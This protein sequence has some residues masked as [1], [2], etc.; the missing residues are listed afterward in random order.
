MLS[1]GAT[2]NTSRRIGRTASLPYLQF[3]SDDPYDLASGFS[4][5]P[6]ADGYV[7]IKSDYFG[8]YWRL[9]PNWIW[10]DESRPWSGDRLDDAFWTTRITDVT[11]AFRSAANGNYLRGLSVDWKDDCLNAAVPTITLDTR[12]AVQELVM[13]REVYDVLYRMECARIYDAVPYVGGS[14]EVYN[15][16]DN[17]AGMEVE[18]GYEDFKSTCFSRSVTVSA[19]VEGTI[20]AGVPGIVDLEVKISYSIS[21]TFEWGETEG[22]TGEGFGEGGG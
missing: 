18:L 9:S 20:K 14:T 19:G 17:E 10:A 1:R 2:V 21:G 5:E 8:K 6:R 22:K 15:Y 16:D 13:E 7:R 11:V 4:I 12:M 3:S